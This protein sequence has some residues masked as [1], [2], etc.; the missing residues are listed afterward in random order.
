MIQQCEDTAA[1]WESTK[2]S[3][4][5]SLEQCGSALELLRQYQNIKNNLTALI[6]KEEGII[7]QQASYMGKDNLKKKIAEIETVKE[8]FSDHL[9]VVDKINQIC[10]NLQYHL[11]KMKTFEDPPFEKEANAIVDRWLDINEKTEEYGENL[12]RALA[13]WDKLFIIKTTSMSGL[14]RS[15]GKQNPMS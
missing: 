13:L 11:N 14:N 6:Q 3:V 15:L 1:L 9:E 7:S 4:T 8:E 10:K 5:E 12:G 2:A